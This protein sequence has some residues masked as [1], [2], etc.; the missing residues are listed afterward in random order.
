MKKITLSVL[1]AL[2]LTTTVVVN[3]IQ[4][5]H[6]TKMEVVTIPKPTS[7]WSDEEG[8][9][10]NRLEVIKAMD[11]SKLSIAEKRDL[12]KEL[13][14]IKKNLKVGNGGIYLSV[15]AIIIIILLLI[16]IL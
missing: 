5:A 13:R 14:T 7:T 15:G 10:L 12:K 6:A 9:L 11:K 4:A 2:V 16:L 3:P 1:T 8:I